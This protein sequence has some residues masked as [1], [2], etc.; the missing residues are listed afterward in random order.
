MLYQYVGT[1]GVAG[2]LN[3]TWKIGWIIGDV[4]LGLGFVASMVFA[5]L[6]AFKKED[7]V[8]VAD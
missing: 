2:S 4:V 6:P 5:F 3:N 1:S 8:A 7:Q